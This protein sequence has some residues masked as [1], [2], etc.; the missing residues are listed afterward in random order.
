[1][2]RLSQPGDTGRMWATPPVSSPNSAHQWGNTG[3]NSHNSQV[4]TV[5]GFPGA[6]QPLGSH[7]PHHSYNVPSRDSNPAWN[8]AYGVG[9]TAEESRVVQMPNQSNNRQDQSGGGG[10]SAPAIQGRV[11]DTPNRGPDQQSV[12]LSDYQPPVNPPASNPNAQPRTRHSKGE[13]ILEWIPAGEPSAD[14]PQQQAGS[15][16]GSQ[17]PDNSELHT[18]RE[19]LQRLEAALVERPDQSHVADDTDRPPP[20]YDSRPSSPVRGSGQGGSSLSRTS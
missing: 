12:G 11:P 1:M 3:F 14:A 19:R 13:I 16:S 8:T 18:L 17:P 10:H 7:N 4:G 6:T 5:G 2:G 9:S 20:A 15:S